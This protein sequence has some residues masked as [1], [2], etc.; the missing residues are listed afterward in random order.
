MS[1]STE[2]PRRRTGIRPKL[3]GI[4]ALVLMFAFCAAYS[5]QQSAPNQ[6]DTRSPA[7]LASPF[8]EAETLL[9]QGS[10]DQAK[11]KIQE[12]LKLNPSSVEGYNLLGIIYSGQKDYA[13]ALEAFQH[14]L[15]LDPHSTQTCNNLGNL[16]VAQGK[17]DLAEQEFSK[18]LHL[19]PGNRDANYN[20]ALVLMAKGSPAKAILHLQ[21]VR[22]TDIA[23]RFNLIRAY[24]RAGRIAE[25]VELARDLSAQNR[26]DVQ[27]HSTLGVLLASEKQYSA[28]QLELE[29]VS[30][31]QPESFENLYNLGQTYLRTNAYSKAELVLS[32]ALKLKPDSPEALYLL[33]QVYSDQMREVDALDLLARAHKLAPQNTDIIFL[34]ARVSM[35]Q[36]YF[37]DA[38][39]LLESGLKIAPQRAELRAALGESYFMSGKTDK[40]IEEFKTLIALEP[41][42]RS[43]TLMGLS[44]RQLVR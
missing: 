20:L 5:A 44:Y 36:N 10:V 19:D 33:G 37:E 18:V 9:R 25:G 31:L 29:K 34:L 13:N 21:R 41:S 28:A 24:L 8:L 26:D 39:P 11:E 35:S 15:K 16:Y 14:A 3:Y 27:L 7:N 12:Q 23:T 1:A 22:P 4:L 40:A 30:A 43:Y 38:I 2:H 17:L 42:A 32:R 6:R